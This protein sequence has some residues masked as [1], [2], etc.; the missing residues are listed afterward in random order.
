M[1]RWVFYDPLIRHGFFEWLSRLSV[2]LR[3]GR[4]PWIPYRPTYS[5]AFHFLPESFFSPECL[6]SYSPLRQYYLH[7]SG[8]DGVCFLL[9]IEVLLFPILPANVFPHPLRKPLLR[10]SGFSLLYSSHSLHLQ[11]SSQTQRYSG[12]R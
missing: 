1:C 12:V 2:L 7:Q 5:S 11:S 4:P 9:P 6:S 10:T 3:P 8:N